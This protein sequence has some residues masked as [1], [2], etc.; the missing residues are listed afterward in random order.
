MQMYRRLYPNWYKGD[1][2]GNNKVFNGERGQ[3]LKIR[4]VKFEDKRC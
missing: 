4:Y 2:G 3:K 1:E